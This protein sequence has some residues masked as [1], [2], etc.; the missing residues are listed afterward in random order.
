MILVLYKDGPAYYHAS[1]VVIIDVVDEESFQR[2]K[3][4]CKRAMD[5]PNI[6]GLNRLCETMGK[7][8]ICKL[9]FSFY[10]CVFRNC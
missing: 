7:V 1:Y 6:I 8:R 2:R 9:S 3:D 10:Q 5:V 4:M